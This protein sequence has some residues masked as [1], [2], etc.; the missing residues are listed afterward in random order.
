MKIIIGVL[1]FL[2]VMALGLAN[3][4]AGPARPTIGDVLRHMLILAVS[5]ALYFGAIVLVV[6]FFFFMVG[7]VSWIFT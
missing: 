4:D 6:V 7:I 3:K 2:F 5:Y 1:L